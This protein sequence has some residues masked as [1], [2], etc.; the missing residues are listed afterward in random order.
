MASLKK[1][2]LNYA[3]DPFSASPARSIHN[4]AEINVGAVKDMLHVNLIENDRFTEFISVRLSTR[5][6][7]FFDPIKKVKLNYG[8]EKPKVTPSAVNILKEDRQA[9]GIIIS[10]AYR[11]E[12]TFSYPITSVTLSE[13][14]LRQGEKASFRNFLISSAEA[15]HSHI[16]KNCFWYIDG[17]AA[18]RY[19]TRR[20][21]S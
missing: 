7:S 9:F 6:K 12:E 3:F 4:G 19:K 17:I 13:G 18:V 14:T 5:Q 1:Q 16:P 10:K 2:F 21:L 15:S 11:L 20:N 8:V